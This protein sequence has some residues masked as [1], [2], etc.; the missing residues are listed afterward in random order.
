MRTEGGQRRFD[1]DS[2][3]RR[4]GVAVVCYGR[5]SAANQRDDLKRRRKYKG[6][7]DQTV[8]DGATENPV[9]AMV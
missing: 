1:V 4:G 3:L 5:V 9:E 6:K 8:S 7:T 2:Y